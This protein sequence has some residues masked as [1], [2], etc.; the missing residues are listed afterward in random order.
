LKALGKREEARAAL[1]KAIKMEPGN[2]LARNQLNE[3]QGEQRTSAK[4]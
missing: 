3:L 2:E 4:P 1:E